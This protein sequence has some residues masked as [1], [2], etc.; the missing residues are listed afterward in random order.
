MRFPLSNQLPLPNQYH[1]I[2]PSITSLVQWG[3]E[4]H[5]TNQDMLKAEITRLKLQRDAIDNRIANLKTQSDLAT[6]AVDASQN[7]KERLRT[8]DWSK[9]ST[10]TL[11]QFNHLSSDEKKDLADKLRATANLRGISAHLIIQGVKVAKHRFNRNI[12]SNI[13]TIQ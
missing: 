11:E 1:G 13:S 5:V 8:N 12:Y 3:E 10:I 9:L 7:F 2:L 6:R 4:I